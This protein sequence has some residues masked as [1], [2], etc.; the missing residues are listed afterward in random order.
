MN[1]GFYFNFEKSIGG[2]HFWRC[3]NIAKKL[4]RPGIKFFFLSNMKDKYFLNLLKKEKITFIR[5]D[6][7]NSYQIK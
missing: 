7:K 6:N 1:I 2:G 5:I 4:K 3:L